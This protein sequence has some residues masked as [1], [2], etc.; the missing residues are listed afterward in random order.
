MVMRGQEND[1]C[2]GCGDVDDG[3]S[4]PATA[5]QKPVMDRNYLAGFRVEASE[6]LEF[7]V[8]ALWL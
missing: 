2:H 7:S 3:C 8:S 5:V 4:I 1:D 6:A